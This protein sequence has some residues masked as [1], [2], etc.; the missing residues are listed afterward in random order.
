[1]SACVTTSPVRST[2]LGS[3]NAIVGRVAGKRRPTDNEG[4]LGELFKEAFLR[5]PV[6]EEVQGLGWQD[7]GGDKE[8][9][10]CCP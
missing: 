10:E 5:W 9:R 6:D 7:E 1:M 3:R 4:V 2:Q 8:E